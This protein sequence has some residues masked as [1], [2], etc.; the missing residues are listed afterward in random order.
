MHTSGFNMTVLIPCS[1]T[2]SY[3]D[4]SPPV[5]VRGTALNEAGKVRVTWTRPT[6]RSGLVI[7]G[8]RVQYRRSGYHYYTT[9][10]VSASSTSYTISNLNLGTVYEVRV[11]TASN[12]GISGYCCGNGKQVATY[13][14]EC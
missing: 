5:S 1:S 14:C 13:N 9:R 4:L 6:V 2:F 7:T 3:A 11:A 12:L 10:S 8:Y